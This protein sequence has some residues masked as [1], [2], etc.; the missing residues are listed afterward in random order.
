MRQNH[1]KRRGSRAGRTPG[2]CSQ[3]HR[4]GN[5]S[6]ARGNT[7]KR[8][9]ERS[10][11]SCRDKAAGPDCQLQQRAGRQ[12]EAGCSLWKCL[13]TLHAPDLGDPKAGRYLHRRLRKSNPAPV[14]RS[15]PTAGLG[16][17]PLCRFTGHPRRE[18]PLTAGVETDP[19]CHRSQAGG[20]G[21]SICQSPGTENG[22]QM[23][24]CRAAQTQQL[25]PCQASLPS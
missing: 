13:H 20:S 15:S 25:Q 6:D 9:R 24:H 4:K 12:Q 19:R 1:K 18:V 14:E 17:A 3:S 10:F 16:H 11:V 2:Y 21:S 23:G 5:M 22:F 8:Q 7:E